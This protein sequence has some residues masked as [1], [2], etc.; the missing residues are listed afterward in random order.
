M[1]VWMLGKRWDLMARHFV[2][3]SGTMT[4]EE[5]LQLILTRLRATLSKANK[6]Q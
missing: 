6:A 1:L 3:L 5:K 2:D 4:E